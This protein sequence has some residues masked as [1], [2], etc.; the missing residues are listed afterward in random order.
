MNYREGLRQALLANAAL[1]ALVPTTQLWS[2]FAP[3]SSLASQPW[4]VMTR[5]SSIGLVAHDGDGNLLKQRYQL[6]IGGPDKGGVDAIQDILEQQFNGITFNY[7]E[8][9]VTYQLVI[10]LEGSREGWDPSTR[11][12]NPSVDLSVWSNH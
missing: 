6:T 2:L 11:L 3:N 10:W 1:A 4:V 7:V 5:V 12:Y 9:S 8:N